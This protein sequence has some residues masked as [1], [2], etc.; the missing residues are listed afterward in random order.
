[1][2]KPRISLI[3]AIDSRGGIGKDNT[4]PW[5][6]SEDLKRF[7]K[8]TTGHP[9]IMGRKTFESILEYI[10][11]PLPNR[12]NIVVT[13]NPDFK[14]EGIVISNSLEDAINKAKK[15]ENREIFIIGGAHVFREVL[16]KGIVN[17]IYLTKVEGDFSCDT[18]FPDYSQFKKVV[19][20]ETGESNGIKFRFINLE[21]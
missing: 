12:V 14:K 3:V 21:R 1:M 20:E 8:L 2:S 7:K 6:I 16:E 9:V 5:H 19:S 18:F 13:Q 17:R 10:G 4:I 15:S 11:K